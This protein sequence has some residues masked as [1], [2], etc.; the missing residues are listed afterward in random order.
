MAAVASKASYD[1]SMPPLALLLLALDVPLTIQ[2]TAGV[3]RNAEPVT[4]GVPLPKGLLTD[5]AKLR[6]FGADGKPV[7]ADFRVV[8]RWWS[9]TPNQVASI[10]WVHC[11]FFASAPAR[12]RAVYHLRIGGDNPAPPPPAKLE[13][14]RNDG[15]VTVNTGPLQFIVHGKGPLLDGPGLNG[16]DIHLR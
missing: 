2:E 12:G 10:Q 13:V 1:A 15:D 4:F 16:A 5:T 14:I 8:N 3:A 7:A 6:L 9:D 11:D